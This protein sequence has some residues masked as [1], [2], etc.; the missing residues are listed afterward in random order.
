MDRIGEL[1]YFN[2]DYKKAADQ[3]R[4]EVT[5]IKLAMSI[6]KGLTR[7][8]TGELSSKGDGLTGNLSHQNTEIAKNLEPNP[9]SS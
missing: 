2:K 8:I 3:A 9:R 4:E 5:K 7:G 6:T 1:E